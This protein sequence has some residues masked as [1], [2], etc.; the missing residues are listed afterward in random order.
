MFGCFYHFG[1]GK[2]FRF[3]AVG[4]Y[5]DGTVDVV[6]CLSNVETSAKLCLLTLMASA[7]LTL[8]A[9]ILAKTSGRRSFKPSKLRWQCESIKYMVL[10]GKSSAVAAQA[11]A[12]LGFDQVFCLQAAF[13]FRESQGLRLWDG[14]LKC[15][16]D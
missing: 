13:V 11:R 9:S 14:G 16:P 7:C 10:Q 8:C 4:M 12:K 3:L 6:V 1:N 5:A 15:A 2:F